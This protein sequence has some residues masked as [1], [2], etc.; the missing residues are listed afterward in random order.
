MT[1]FKVIL[2]LLVSMG[3]IGVGLTYAQSKV[4]KEQIPN[5]IT[6]EIIRGKEGAR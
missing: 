2:S 5:N 3:F 6:G 4:L 1:R